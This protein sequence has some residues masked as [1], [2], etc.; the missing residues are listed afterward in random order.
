MSRTFSLVA[1][2]AR[3]GAKCPG[4]QVQEPALEGGFLG[5][6]DRAVRSGAG[7]ARLTRPCAVRNVVQVAQR[8]SSPFVVGAL[9]VR[10]PSCTLRD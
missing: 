9:R 4:G 10:F 8:Q 5:K 2:A 7:N 6:A 3:Q 1:T